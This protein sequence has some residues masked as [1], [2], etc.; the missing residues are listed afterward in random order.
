MRCHPRTGEDPRAY[1]D[2]TTTLHA[3][4]RHLRPGGLALVGECFWETPP[5]PEVLTGLDARLD[6]YADLPGTVA[7]AESTGYATVYAH[8]SERGEWDEYEW[9]W[10]GTLTNWALDHP[11]PDGDAALAAARDHRDMWLNGYRDTLGSVTLLLR[12]TG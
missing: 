10:T 4:R 7:R 3:V 11:G 5:T 1:G 8:T 6:D 9:S 12:Q 2:L